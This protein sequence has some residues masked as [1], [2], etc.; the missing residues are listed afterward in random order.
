MFAWEVS[1]P[2]DS[3]VFS[4]YKRKAGVYFCLTNIVT[5]K[6]GKR[7]FRNTVSEQ[8]CSLAS[9]GRGISKKEREIQGAHIS[10]NSKISHFKHG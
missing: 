9:V 4:L 2:M 7:L 8:M 1:L 6:L 5:K 10:E 3:Q